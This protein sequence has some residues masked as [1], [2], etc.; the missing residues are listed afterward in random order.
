MWRVLVVI[1][2]P[3]LRPVRGMMGA[4]CGGRKP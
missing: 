2:G 1:A 3:P 4:P